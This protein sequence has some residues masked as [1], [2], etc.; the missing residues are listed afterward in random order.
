MLVDP[1]GQGR[2]WLKNREAPN[3]LKIISLS[4]K[5]FRTILEVRAAAQP[6]LR[7]SCPEDSPPQRANSSVLSHMRRPHWAQMDWV[8]GM[9]GLCALLLQRGWSAADF[10]KQ[11]KLAWES[12]TAATCCWGSAV[13]HVLHCLVQTQDC[14]VVRPG[15]LAASWHQPAQQAAAC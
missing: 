11:L 1:Q 15:T 13:Q 5:H 7:A 6:N 8:G 3:N 12:A 9:W 4:D 14:G 10:V 2:N